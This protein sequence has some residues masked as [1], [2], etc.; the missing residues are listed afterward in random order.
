MPTLAR[1][2]LR[3]ALTGQET[4][5]LPSSSVASSVLPVAGFRPFPAGSTVVTNDDVNALRETE[6]V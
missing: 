4:Q 1:L 2:M 5:I 3:R 6:G